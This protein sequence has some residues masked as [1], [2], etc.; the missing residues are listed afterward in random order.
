VAHP[1]LD[2]YRAFLERQGDGLAAIALSTDDADRAYADLKDHGARAPMDLSRPVEGGVARFRL[3]QIR[4][5]LFVCQHQ[6]RELVWRSEW[7][8]HPNGAS[9]LVTVAWRKKR[10]FDGLP[11]SI[12]W[13]ASTALRMRGLRGLLE[14]HGVR[15]APA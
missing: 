9:E 4:D 7:Q 2:Y 11:P 15:L 6:T 13:Q 14:A 1:W 8:K 10:P 5:N 12:E 3:V